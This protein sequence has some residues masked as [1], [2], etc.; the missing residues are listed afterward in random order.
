MKTE[1]WYESSLYDIN[2]MVVLARLTV[3]DDDTAEIL[4]DGGEQYEF[5]SQDQAE[6]WL[7]D[8]EYYTLDMLYETFA[9]QGTPIDPRIKPP[10]ASC[11]GDLLKQMVIKLG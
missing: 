11:D 5:A 3:R 2:G 6:I 10:C 7:T 8:E 9:E 4:T 1:W